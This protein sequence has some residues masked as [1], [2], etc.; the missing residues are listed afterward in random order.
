MSAWLTY[1]EATRSGSRLYEDAEGLV[2]ENL[3]DV[4][5]VVERAKASYAARRRSSRH[6]AMS[7][8]A[9]I[10]SAVWFSLPREL[11]SDSKA[12]LKWL[13]SSEQS[14]F[15]TRPGRLL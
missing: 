11:R 5:P 13:E 9:S 7:W 8:V 10:P 2:L 3:A 6:G 12:L 15:R 1:D 14:V 4:E